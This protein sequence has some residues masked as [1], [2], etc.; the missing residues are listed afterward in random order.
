M[1]TMHLTLEIKCAFLTTNFIND[2][3]YIG[4]KGHIKKIL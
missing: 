1:D 2:H 3:Y 4:H